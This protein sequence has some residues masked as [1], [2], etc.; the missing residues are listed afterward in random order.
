MTEPV[1]T[2][3]AAM[4]FFWRR[5][6]VVWH[7]LFGVIVAVAIAVAV[8]EES[9]RGT[10]GS[11]STS[12]A[13]LALVLTVPVYAVFGT[14]G[15]AGRSGASSL[16]YLGFAWAAVAIGIAVLAGGPWIMLFVLYPQTWAMLG[17]TQAALVV[18]TA[19]VTVGA[20][21]WS[22]SDWDPQDFGVNLTQTLV[23][24]AVSLALGLFIHSLVGEAEKRAEI[25]DEL[26]ATRA[27][28]A[29]AERAQ[30][31][32]V[33]RER[34]SR[35]IHDTLAQGFTS[36]IALSRAAIA[37]TE[38]AD[39][40]RALEQL[41]LIEATARDNLSEARLIVAEL[42][43]GH[44]QSRTLVE[45]LERLGEAV[46]RESGM[47]GSVRLQGEPQPLPADT[48]VVLLRAA[49]EALSNARRHAGASSFSVTLSYADPARVELVVADDGRGFDPARPRSGYGLDGASA[50]AAELSGDFTV[51]TTPGHGTRVTVGVPR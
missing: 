32:S 10:L 36:I 1:D 23:S 18:V 33:E 9:A 24:V 41:A 4:A 2:S 16:V 3:R 29:A 19:S 35:E 21:S 45:A 14:R 26:T 46:I 15:L 31:T 20:A 12:L 43:P 6:A 30:G 48:E 17:R 27:E 25:I 38:R 42:T 49:Q 7:G 44:L 47:T 39:S 40:A 37:A 8:S 5:Q 51:D 34:I 11:P 13:I 50:R 28:L 22:R